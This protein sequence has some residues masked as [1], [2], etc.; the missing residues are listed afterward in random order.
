MT[1]DETAIKQIASIFED[2]KD[3]N[4]NLRIYITGGGCA[5]FNYSFA[6]DENQNDDD[7]V[8]YEDG[9][10]VLVDTMSYTYLGEATVKYE[11][12]LMGSNFV[13]DNPNATSTCGCGSSFSC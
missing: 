3:K 13:I 12:G 11:S 8:I 7:M 9:W 1:L 6:F 2:E 10:K 5:G 4:L